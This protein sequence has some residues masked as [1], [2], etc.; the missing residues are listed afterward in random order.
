MIMLVKLEEP[1]IANFAS[2]TTV[3][4]WRDIFLAVADNL[5]ISKKN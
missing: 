1:Q 5:E 4:I 3:P 2:L